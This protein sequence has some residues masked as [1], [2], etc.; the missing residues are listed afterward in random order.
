M[1]TPVAAAATSREAPRLTREGQ[2]IRVLHVNS[3]NLFGGVE[4]FL[5]TLATYGKH[6]PW[7]VTEYA[8]C[9]DARIASEL[10]Q[11]GAKVHIVG[12]VQMRSPRSVAAARAKLLQIIRQGGYDVVV[13][14][15]AW[16]H[17]VFAPAIRKS[18][19]RFVQ[20]MHDIPNRRGWIDHLANRTAPD[21]VLCNT[22]FMETSGPWWFARVPRRM[23]RYPVPL[24]DF[25]GTDVRARV[26]ASLDTSLDSVVVLH[27]SRMQ[28]W[29]GHRL[30][31][32]TLG[33][34]KDNPRWTCWIAGGSQRPAEVEY[35]A[36]LQA[37]VDRLGLTGRV[38]FLGHRNDVPAVMK[39]ADI[40]CQPNIAPEPF[41]VSFLEALSAGLPIVTTAMGGPLEIVDDRCGVLVPPEVG[42]VSR[43][44]GAMVDDDARRARMSALAPVRAREMCEVEVRIRELADTLAAVKSSSGMIE[45]HDRA[46]LSE[47]RSSDAVLS[48]VVS[49][50]ASKGARFGTMVDLGCG[51][52]DCAR[53][54]EGRYGAYVGGDLVE[55][56]KFPGA[57]NVSFRAVDLNQSPYPFDS[58]SADLVVSVE[59]IEHVENPR[60]LVREMA[61]IVRPG[62]WIVVSTPNQLSLSSKLYLVV[63]DQFPAFQEAPG[64][65]PSHITAL[66]EQDLRRIAAEAGLVDVAIRYT[67]K[68]RVPLTGRHWPTSLGA[69]GRWFSD[70]VVMVARRP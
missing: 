55:Y 10:R 46:A 65:Y 61:R 51:R 48:T 23:V 37:E 39:A 50:V 30:L 58:A 15:S 4:W 57:S 36:Q 59:T 24:F 22:R 14:H 26:R 7:M 42:A 17:A 62:G 66:V 25:G 40:Y 52:G 19:A 49:V 34:L 2:Q 69:R 16:P 53:A 38:K 21:L 56:E 9:Y 1:S 68:G 28:E 11:L 32:E 33:A 31:I 27:A 47:G 63:R 44:L 43:A 5:R 64:L 13:C 29:K 41:G 3:G 20:F 6:A 67:D 60:A 12:S 70:N 35:L 8:L 18:G 54:L 45:A